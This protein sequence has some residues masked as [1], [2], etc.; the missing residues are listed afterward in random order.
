M[1]IAGR[2]LRL[3]LRNRWVLAAVGLLLVLALALHALGTLPAGAVEATAFRVAVVSLA[4][5]GVYLLP[6]LGVMLGHDAFVGERE[7]GTL[8]LLL[9]APVGRA[10][11]V[12]GKLL[13]HAAVLGL[14]IALGFGGAALVIAFGG[15]GGAAW[16]GGAAYLRMM[17]GSWLLGLVFVAL[18]YLVS[19][20]TRERTTAGA[21]AIGV[22]LLLVVIYDL[23][24]IGV[25][26]AGGGEWLDASL[27]A[28][29][30]ALN[31]TDAYRLLTLAGDAEVARVAGLLGV[32]SDLALPQ[33]AELGVL[34]AWLLAPLALVA[35]L[36]G[37]YEP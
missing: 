15:D 14:A 24:L 29:L 32:T 21:I 36:L 12:A 35:I 27:F 3:G 10:A 16:A 30:V 33:G 22:W 34:F 37:R 20:G 19:I 31:P 4:S 5:L 2:E 9:A 11:L 7:R 1:A 6:L 25:A 23:A 26:L 18:G 13:G 17:L 8:A 28:W